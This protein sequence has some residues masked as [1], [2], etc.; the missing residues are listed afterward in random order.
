MEQGLP[1]QLVLRL[2]GED[3]SWECLKLSDL[4][5]DFLVLGVNL[6]GITGD[7][8]QIWS[9]DRVKLLDDDAGLL[10]ILEDVFHVAWSVKDLFGL[11]EVPSL[12][13]LLS[14]DVS[15]GL[16][17]FFGPFL[18][19]GLALLDD[20]NGFVWRLLED[21]GDVNLGLDLVTDLI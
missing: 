9:Q 2:V 20:L 11:L 12:D 13:G 3:I 5:L 6:F 8:F 1:L 16:L 21:L 14:L 19:H 18:K 15:P 4:V 7:C 10:E 17:E